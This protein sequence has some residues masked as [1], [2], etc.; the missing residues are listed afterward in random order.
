MWLTT[1]MYAC[2][3]AG[4]ICCFAVH[5]PH[6]WAFRNKAVHRQQSNLFCDSM[7]SSM[8]NV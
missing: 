6:L 5:A 8:K 7:A 4:F 2:S 3:Y 1:V